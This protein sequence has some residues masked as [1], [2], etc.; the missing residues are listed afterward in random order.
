MYVNISFKYTIGTGLILDFFFVSVAYIYDFK[1]YSSSNFEVSKLQ[2]F[3]M[4]YK[5]IQLIKEALTKRFVW[6]WKIVKNLY[7]IEFQY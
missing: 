5:F 6:D 7:I 3:W 1:K 2:A 4:K